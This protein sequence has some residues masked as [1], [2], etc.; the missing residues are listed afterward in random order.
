MKISLVYKLILSSVFLVLISVGVVGWVFYVKTTEIL[1]NKALKSI[2]HE[3]RDAGNSLQ[4]IVNA[5]D[6]NV[7]FLA[8]TQALQ[9]MI[10]ERLHTGH[11]NRN[12]EWFTRLE[13]I[14]ESLLK[15]KSKYKKIRFIDRKGQELISVYRSDAGIESAR[16]DLLQ[17]K[18]HR[19][20]VYE[21]LKLP[22]G[23]V[24]LS[25]INLNREYGEVQIPY[26]EVFRVATPVYDE[27]TN[28]LSGLIVITFDIG[29]ELRAI[30]KRASSRGDSVIYITND[31][32]GYLVHPDQKKNYGFDLD[33]RYRLQEDIPQL[34]EH[35]L[36]ASTIKNITLMPE[37]T[38]GNDVVNL[39]KI[40]FDRNHPQRFITVVVTQD[41]DTIVAE[42]STLL[43]EIVYWALILAF[44]GVCLAVVFSIRITRPLQQMRNAI[45]SYSSGSSHLV[46]LPITSSDEFGV[47][48]KSFNLMIQQVELSQARLEEMNLNLESRVIDRTKDLNNARLE[49][50][51]ANKAKSEFLSRMSHELRTPMNAILGFGQLLELD[52]GNFTLT[53]RDNV[54]E[55]L[56]AGHHL[57]SLI[58]EVLDLA[59][60]ESGKLELFMGEVNVNDVVKQSAA[61]IVPLAESRHITL[62]DNVSAKELVVRA[63][64]TRFKQV[65][66]NFLS[67]AVKYNREY[68][69]IIVDCDVI[70]EGFLR[71]QIT[72]TGEGLTEEEMT[73]L[74]I[75]FERLNEANNVEGTGIG[76]VISKHL[77]E[78]MNG[79]IGV[80]SIPGKGSCFWLE[81]A[82][83]SGA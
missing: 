5:D 4:K 19:A 10:H 13:G 43:N 77:V 74:F 34:A 36:P 46:S 9:G 17:N 40:A 70:T 33:K 49:A 73:K 45:N 71:I 82:L 52:I 3:V 2:A 59:R 27:L 55:I 37:D 50:E 75:P 41:Y 39:T 38:S 12:S 62:M 60:I 6:E 32:G 21:T 28:L 64:I 79:T 83:T 15:K 68:G 25:P 20:Y 16:E 14:F 31:R 1:V 8:S 67:N 63:D 53:Q 57:L 24:Y 54:R 29:Q 80:E 69:H 47:L 22:V 65:L 66:V 7:L 11:V 76:L 26:Q 58:N 72:D 48:A 18:T 35:F 61:L 56:D 78:L 23:K 51:N 30:Q 44:G 81:L 42:A